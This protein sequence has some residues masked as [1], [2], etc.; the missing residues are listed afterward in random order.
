MEETQKEYLLEKINQ[1]KSQSSNNS[2]NWKNY[3]VAIATCSFVLGI[4]AMLKTDSLWTTCSAVAK[5]NLQQD[6]QSYSE[7]IFCA[8]CGDFDVLEELLG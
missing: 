5:Y 6:T 7:G 3:I 1:V 2:D 8:E 4:L